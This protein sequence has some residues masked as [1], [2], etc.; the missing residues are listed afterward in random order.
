MGAPASWLGEVDTDGALFLGELAALF[1]FL[2]RRAAAVFERCEALGVAEEAVTL[3]RALRAIGTLP[4]HAL[5]GMRSM[6]PGRMQ[7]DPLEGFTLALAPTQ[8]LG[9]GVR[10]G[11]S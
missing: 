2:H 1:G 5:L 10:M 4:S 9:G 11:D 3:F 8:D 6:A 7:H